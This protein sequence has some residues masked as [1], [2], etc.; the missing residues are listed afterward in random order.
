M[1][2]G[3]RETDAR[4]FQSVP[5]SFPRLLSGLGNFFFIF[6]M[7]GRPR[8]LSPVPNRAGLFQ[9]TRLSVL[10]P[11]IYFKP[12][13]DLAQERGTT[14]RMGT[15]L[16]WRTRTHYSR[17]FPISRSTQ[18]GS[19]SFGP[20]PCP[21]HY[22]TALG[23]YTAFALC[24]ACWHSRTPC[25]CRMDLVHCASISPASARKRVQSSTTC[26]FFRTDALSS[27]HREKF[28]PDMGGKPCR[29]REKHGEVVG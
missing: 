25:G 4:R 21:F 24:P 26:R 22:R 13:S 16:C 28:G 12:Y 29:S 17:R 19:T 8:R 5:R 2:A 7:I 1:S 20:S 23:Y 9:G 11:L 14:R 27:Q 10:A 6:V 18:I 3:E 15:P